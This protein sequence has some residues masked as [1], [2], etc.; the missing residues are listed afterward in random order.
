[1]SYG[2]VAYKNA[3]TSEK[4]LDPTMIGGRVFVK[5]ISLAWAAGSGVTDYSI[6]GVSSDA[7]LKVYTVQGGSHI[8][9]TL[10]S[11]GTAVIRLTAV[12]TVGFYGGY[13]TVLLVFATQTVEPDY[14]IL[15]TNDSGE[16]IVSTIYPVPQFLE[17]VTFD[18]NGYTVGAW[19]ALRSTDR[20]DGTLTQGNGR[21]KIALFTIPQT[22]N[23]AWYVLNSFIGTGIG[24]FSIDV[25][26]QD[27][28][29]YGL[30]E[31]YIFALDGFSASSE[32]YG[33]RIFDSAGSLVFDTGLS[34]MNI[35]GFETL[36]Y[37]STDYNVTSSL[38]SSGTPAVLIPGYLR[39]Q[40]QR[41]G[42]S[43]ASYIYQDF[44]GIKRNGSTITSKRI[45][46][47]RNYEDAILNYTLEMGSSTNITMA[48]DVTP[49]V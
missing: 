34:Y 7:Y 42:T 21:M 36:V 20:H 15:T 37:G 11:G 38:Y 39:E 25:E 6:P 22:N 2:I 23:D 5:F 26:H 48:A 49:Y 28:I 16:R 19:N 1:M 17:K 12:P 33:M 4:N 44:G 35:K 27:N 31:A 14:G 30:P 8:V 47:S 43:S 45:R 18:P 46:T 41:I 10:T 24:A 13:P 32:N 9:S 3:A 40:A 29:T